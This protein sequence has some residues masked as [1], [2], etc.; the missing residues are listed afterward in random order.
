M[1]FLKP[2]EIANVLRVSTQT[3]RRLIDSGTIP[4]VV[5]GKQR[6]VESADLDRYLKRTSETEGN[7]V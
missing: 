6:R 5:V 4:S 1:S 3:V 7:D 2:T